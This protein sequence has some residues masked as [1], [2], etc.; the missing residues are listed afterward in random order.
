MKDTTSSTD[1]I[2]SDKPLAK[3]LIKAEKKPQEPLKQPKETRNSDES[4]PDLSVGQPA[5]FMRRSLNLAN[6]LR[7]P[8]A[9]TTI[10]DRRKFS[11]TA[12]LDS[13]ATDSFIDR[14]TIKKHNL[15]VTE[16][17]NPIPVYNADGNRNKLGDI[18]GYVTLEMAFGNHKERMRLYATSLG[19]D[20]IFIGHDWLKKHNPEI[21]WKTDEVTMTRCPVK[22]CGYTKHQKRSE[23]QKK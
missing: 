23:K 7:L 18:S 14:K 10:K 22:T 12:L 9:F 21:D 4:S 8:L 1:N 19:Q 5:K 3:E 16:L 6:E 2:S 17:E 11:T 15:T 20:R 13:G